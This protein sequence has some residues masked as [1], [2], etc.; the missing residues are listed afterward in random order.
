MPFCTKC[1]FC[2]PVQQVTSPFCAIS[3]SAQAGPMQACDWNGHSYSASITRAAVLERL[4]DV[5]G[6]LGVDLALAHGRLADVIVERVL[7]DERR[8]H[9][10]PFDLEL[11]RRLDGVP[12]LVGDDAEEAL[13]PDHLG[14]RDVADRAFVDLHRHARPRPP[15]GSCGRAA[16]RAAFTSV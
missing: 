8:L 4:I 9:V 12:L 1:G 2:E 16:C 13:V 15:D 7:I 14:A 10:R 3:T 5:A 11:L 6:L